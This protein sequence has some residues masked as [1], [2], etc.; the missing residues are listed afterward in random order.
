MANENWRDIELD[1]RYIAHI[2]NKYKTKSATIAG[3]AFYRPEILKQL[4]KTN[5]SS[6]DKLHMADFVYIKETQTVVKNRLG[7]V[8]ELYESAIK[9]DMLKW[10]AD[11]RISEALAKVETLSA[12][13]R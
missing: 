7:S 2:D 13:V 4:D 8:E 12:L 3:R 1:Q 5:A 11:L 10:N 9:Y 6:I